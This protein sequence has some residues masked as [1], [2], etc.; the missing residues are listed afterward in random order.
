MA[1]FIYWSLELDKPK[2]IQNNRY[3]WSFTLFCNIDRLTKHMDMD[4]QHQQIHAQFS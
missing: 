2:A 4:I 1:K 3:K